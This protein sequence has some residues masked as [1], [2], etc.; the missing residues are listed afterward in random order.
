MKAGYI[1]KRGDLVWLDFSPQAGREQAG[2]R[3]AAVISDSQY[4]QK[5]GL[6]IACPVTSQRKHYPFEVLLPA[7]LPITGVILADQLRSI[8][9][10]SRRPAYIGRL[11]EDILTEILEKLS[12]LLN[13]EDRGRSVIV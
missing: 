11:S 8:D 3:P 12:T 4:N 13:D 7:G 9:W 5:V 10:K 2:R 6:L 1:P